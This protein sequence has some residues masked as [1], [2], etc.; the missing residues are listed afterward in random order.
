[1]S[2]IGIGGSGINLPLPPNSYNNV[3]TNGTNLGVVQGG[4]WQLIPAGT[5]ALGLGKYLFLQMLDP[6][7]GQWRIVSNDSTGT[8]RYVNS[9]G[10][11]YRVANYTG[12]PVGAVVTNAGSGY[13]SAP[14]V[15]ASAG[16]S[17]WTA[18]VGGAIGTI[19]VGTAGANYTF[20]PQVWIA[21]PPAGGVQATAYATL[22]AG[23]V[24]AITVVDNGAGYTKAPTILIVPHPAEPTPGTITA[25]AATTT[26]SGSAGKITAVYPTSLGTPQTSLITLS[27]AGGGGSSAAATVVGCFAITSLTA[28]GGATILPATGNVAVTSVAG[29]TTATAASG[30]A[31]PALSFPFTV[32]Q[33]TGYSPTSGGA[34]T[35]TLVLADGGLFQAVP[36]AQVCGTYGTAPTFTL[37]AGAVN[38]YYWLQPVL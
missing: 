35:G 20:P 37:A 32:R 5:W 9:D 12:C 19:T 36:T 16:G 10:N 24:N 1:M 14:V 30:S 21:P 17:S 3:P 11:N 38:D 23:T 33:A 31:Q 2:V 8:V 28:S 15:T 18:I 27:F 7:S 13:T 34:V 26:I 6:I 29:I 25:A 4:M 22:S